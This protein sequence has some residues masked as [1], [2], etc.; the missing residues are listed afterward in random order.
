MNLSEIDHIIVGIVETHINSTPWAFGR[1]FYDPCS[2]FQH[3]PVFFLNIF[4]RKCKTDISALIILFG[5]TIINRQSCSLRNNKLMRIIIAAII[6]PQQTL[7]KIGQFPHVICQ[8]TFFSNN[9]GLYILSKAYDPIG[10]LK[11]QCHVKPETINIVKLAIA[12]K[13]CTSFFFCPFLAF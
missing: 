6:N 3:F 11:S 5:S 1:W 4:N 12:G 7:I 2:E 8:Q 10:F 9:H 13:F